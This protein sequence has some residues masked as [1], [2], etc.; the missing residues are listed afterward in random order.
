[1]TTVFA[2]FSTSVTAAT[3]R[4]HSPYRKRCEC[5][6]CR[7]VF[8]FLSLH[9]VSIVKRWFHFFLLSIFLFEFRLL[10][11]QKLFL[12]FVVS[13]WKFH[14]LQAVYCTAHKL[15]HMDFGLRK[16]WMKSLFIPCAACIC[17][18]RN[19]RAHIFFSSI[20]LFFRCKKNKLFTIPPISMHELNC[21]GCLLFFVHSPALNSVA[22]Q[23][24]SSFVLCSVWVVALFSC[25][26]CS[27][28][29]IL[30]IFFGGLYYCFSAFKL[31]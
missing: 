23:S 5:L 4:C 22:S 2:S 8:L 1:M 29:D 3:F 16:S 20:L 13:L 31:N 30:C 6:C 27:C 28:V 11:S 15:S 10:S 7:V 18:V 25:L 19:S 9:S 12:A 26:L 14:S 17:G 21:C 24:H